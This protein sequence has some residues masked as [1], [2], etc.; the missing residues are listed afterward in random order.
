MVVFGKKQNNHT[1]DKLSYEGMLTKILKQVAN[2]EGL[3]NNRFQTLQG[4]DINQVYLGTGDQNKYV[5][6][7]NDA[8]QFPDLFL[9]ERNG[10]EELRKSQSFRIPLVIAYG[11]LEGYAYLILEY[12]PPVT[13]QSWQSFGIQLA[14]LHQY[15]ADV[16]G[17]AEWNYIGSLKQYNNAAQNA[18]AFFIEQRLMPQFEL[19]IQKS[20]KFKN[21]D[22]LYK[23]AEAIIPDEAPSLI[24]GDLWSGNYLHTGEGFALIDP[25][26]SYS[27]REMDLAMMQLFG[28]FPNEV[29]SVYNE[30][31]AT[32]PDLEDRIPL[33]Q[34]YYILV[35]LNL[36]G[37]SYYGRAERIIDKYL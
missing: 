32:S 26:V 30:C 13:V 2:Q 35:H 5:F 37:S 9:K 23:A 28:G 1:L 33:Y 15:K 18:A 21:L 36:F 6:K 16:F 29:L 27:I 31:Y 8:G 4:G 7:I 17:L 19:A 25:A 34:L 24:H 14:K 10:L 11:E 20:F 22:K 3:E 12:L